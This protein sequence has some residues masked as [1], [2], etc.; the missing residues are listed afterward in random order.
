M[1]QKIEVPRCRY[2]RFITRA[3][4]GEELVAPE[5]DEAVKGKRVV[6][7]EV[8]DAHPR[9]PTG[10]EYNGI[11]SHAKMTHSRMGAYCYVRFE[12]KSVGPKQEVQVDAKS[13]RK[14]SVN[15]NNR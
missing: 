7:V 12:D 10:T 8:T 14:T 5:L 1:V 15:R 4:N 13:G 2:R 6:I 3:R 9:R 11:V